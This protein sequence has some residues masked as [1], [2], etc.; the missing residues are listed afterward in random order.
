MHDVMFICWCVCFYYLFSEIL[1]TLTARLACGYN[2]ITFLTMQVIS[3]IHNYNRL[4]FGKQCGLYSY[5]SF[6][7]KYSHS[8]MIQC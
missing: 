5:D 7:K 6:T 8:H 3:C 2:S 4:D 1:I